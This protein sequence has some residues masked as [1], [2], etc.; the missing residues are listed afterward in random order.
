MKKLLPGFVFWFTITALHAQVNLRDSSVSFSMIG[1]SFAYQIPGGDMADRFGNNF[2]VGGVFQLKLKNNL[3]FGFDGN[4]L[5]NEHIRETG[6]LDSLRD[7]DGFFINAEGHYA[8]I[9]LVERGLKFELKAGKIF[10][11]IGPNKNS[12]ILATLGAGIL[13]HKIRFETEGGNYPSIEGDYAKGYDRLT[14][15]LSITEF[16]GYINF[17]NKRLVNFYGGIE[18]TQAFTK[19]RRSI[20]FD[21]R[22][23]DTQS[24]LDLLFGF[25]FAW[26]IP[27]YKRAPKQYY[28]D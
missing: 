14:N 13:Q 28:F 8:S 5:F 10:P 20:N 16:I 23:Q 26:I 15:G 7:A 9:A 21:T 2:N 3:V 24:R 6:V 25:R 22:K 19:N 4:F 18:C 1:A 27:I 11:V 17:G 12:G